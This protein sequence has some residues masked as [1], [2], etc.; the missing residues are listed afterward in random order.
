MYSYPASIDRFF[1][2]RN[3]YFFKTFL[4]LWKHNIFYIFLC[5]TVS[6]IWGIEKQRYFE[7]TMYSYTASSDR[8]SDIFLLWKHYVQNIFL[9]RNRLWIRNKSIP[10]KGILTSRFDRC[11]KIIV[12]WKVKIY[13]TSCN[14]KTSLYKQVLQLSEETLT[15]F[16][17]R[18]KK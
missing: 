3:F 13:T 12:G 6:D 18:S 11:S 14:G 17:L 9:I 7:V 15:A 5:C 8:F 2:L 4:L 10:K 1:C 16:L